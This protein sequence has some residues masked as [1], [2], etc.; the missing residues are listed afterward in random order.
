MQYYSILATLCDLLKEKSAV[1]LNIQ[2]VYCSVLKA[3]TYIY[4][5]NIQIR[6]YPHK[7]IIFTHTV[8]AQT[9]PR[10][11]FRCAYVLS[12]TISYVSTFICFRLHQTENIHG[13][14]YTLRFQCASHQTCIN[15]NK[16]KFYTPRSMHTCINAYAHIFVPHFCMYYIFFIHFV[17]MLYTNGNRLSNFSQPEQCAVATSLVLMLEIRGQK[18]KKKKKAIV[19]CLYFWCFSITKQNNSD[20]FFI[21]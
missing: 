13:K 8:N 18:Y 15:T 7:A 16:D 4:T 9:H 3:F 6:Q 21:Q 12:N 11:S 20:D 2:Q 17:L 10:I 5:C 19:C 14:E 1:Y